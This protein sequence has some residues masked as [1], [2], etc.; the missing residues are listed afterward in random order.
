MK[1]LTVDDEFVSRMKAQKILSQ[2]GECDAAA[3]GKE[4]LEA[5]VGAH[6]ERTPYDLIFM[7]IQMEDLDGIA[8]LKKIRTHEEAVGI[9]FD[10]RVKVVM[11][12]SA[13]SLQ[14]VMDSYAQ[15]CDAY[16]VKPFDDSKIVKA[17]QETGLSV[18]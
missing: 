2:Y 16:V 6:G 11:L 14:S 9:P 4:A 17:I 1:I 13:S 3:G 8:T 15:E 12:T 18:G 10:E 7:D 5:F